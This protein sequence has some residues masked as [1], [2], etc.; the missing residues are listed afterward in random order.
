MARLKLSEGAFQAAFQ[1][2]QRA[3]QKAQDFSPFTQARCASCLAH[4]ALARGDLGEANH[5]VEQMPTDGDAHSFYM[6]LNLIKPR[7]LIAQGKREAAAAELQACYD[8]ASQQGWGYAVIAV[9]VLQCLAA[10]SAESA[11]EFLLD[12]LTLAQPEGF[13]RIFADE[14]EALIPSLQEVAQRGKMVEYIGE[15][16]AVMGSR[17]EALAGSSL[18]EPLS[19]R[20]M[21]VLRLLVAGLSNREMAGKL[22][23]SLGTVKTHIHNIYGKLGVRNRAEA[24][25]RARELEL[26]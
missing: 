22:I 11:Y 6:F 12:A 25:K 3:N 14:G 16:L 21:E 4:I 2:A 19:Q 8:R 7:L 5:W 20:E 1:A 24:I 9:R 10:D 23:L 26:L 18:V 17:G 15:I 13:I